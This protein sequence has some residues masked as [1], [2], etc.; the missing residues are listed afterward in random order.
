MNGINWAT[1]YM[2]GI[3]RKTS[4]L[5]NEK[6]S[7]ATTLH[8]VESSPSSR[9]LGIG[10]GETVPFH[11]LFLRKME[12]LVPKVAPR[13][14]P[15]RILEDGIKK[16]FFDRTD[17]ITDEMWDDVYDDLMD[18]PLRKARRIWQTIANVIAVDCVGSD[19]NIDVGRLRTWMELFGNAEIFETEPCCFIPHA[20]LMRSQMFVVC[21]CLFYNRNDARDKINAA[22]HNP[23]GLYGQSIVDIMFP[24]V[25]SPFN[26]GIAI[27]ASLFTSH[28]Q[29]GLPTCTINSLLN[30]EIRNYPERLI[31][32]YTQM[33]GGGDQ[34]TFPSGY[35]AKL[36][37]IVKGFI[38][39]NLK[40]G[41]EGKKIVFENM[42]SG[43]FAKITQQKEM[44][45]RAGIKYT[46]SADEAE[47]YK[48]GLPIYDMNDILF[49]HVFQASS[50]GNNRMND[51]N[52]GTTLI[53]AGHRKYD[54]IY[55]S[56][57]PVDDSN[58]LTGIAALKEQAESQRKL[59]HR[60]MRVVTESSTNVYAEKIATKAHAENID[61]D[62]LLAFDPNNM[63]TGKAYSIGDRNHYGSR[64]AIRKVVGT[65]SA[66]EFGT[67]CPE[68]AFKKD[69]ILLF[70]VYATDIEKH[71]AQYWEQFKL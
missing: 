68:D 43:D 22:S 56:G 27:L 36:Q 21:E 5:G 64:L 47:K 8:D 57:I 51:E 24:G 30:A 46:E 34:I 62:A 33:L 55:L 25:V 44:W 2:T 32:I 37:P 40:N 9:P 58:F 12:V 66:Y 70:R 19:G 29:S 3:R 7:D 20:E 54:K 11:P 69:N 65:T 50:F 41:G 38:T 26:P 28:R 42:A 23:V 18:M 60:Y 15:Q 45:Q 71:D 52:L 61:I 35:I 53:Y 67:L 6:S 1:N 10:K 63:E 59:G 16:A 49:A 48:L 31:E 13:T 14:T 39:V 4:A 17:G